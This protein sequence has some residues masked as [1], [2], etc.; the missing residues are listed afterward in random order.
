M[1][2]WSRRFRVYSI[3]GRKKLTRRLNVKSEKGKYWLP[4]LAMSWMV[5]ALPVR[6]ESTTPRTPDAKQDETLPSGSSTLYTR[7]EVLQA[8]DL[9]IDAALTTAI[10]LAI[11]A[12]VAEKEGQLAAKDAELENARTDRKAADGQAAV[13]GF[14]AKLSG[15]I[16]AAAF[17]GGAALGA[18]LM[19]L[20]K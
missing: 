14:W 10:P 11:Q 12:A 4:I 15:W 19:S 18:W 3:P 16:I 8:V 13:L 9:A 17:G 2:L 1:A 7:D 20:A 5:L 6:G